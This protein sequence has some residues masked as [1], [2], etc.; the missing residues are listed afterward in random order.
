MT[1][2]NSADGRVLWHV[3]EDLDFDA[4]DPADIKAMVERVVASIPLRGD[5]TDASHPRSTAP[6]AGT[7]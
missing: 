6:T 1:L 3:R 4:D 2:V 5:L 7:P